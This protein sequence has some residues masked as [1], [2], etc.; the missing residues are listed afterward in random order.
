MI[1][2][3]FLAT[4]LYGSQHKQMEGSFPFQ[5][6]AEDGYFTTA[7]V[8]CYPENG[9]GLYDLAGNVWEIVQ[10]NY[11][12]GHTKQSKNNRSNP[13]R[14]TTTAHVI[15][16]GSYLCTPEFCMRYR[17]TARQPQDYTMG[18]SHIGFRTVLNIY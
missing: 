16:G 8:G 6:S 17:P 5:N 13:G 15:K 3:T 10:D 1:G 2:I 14:N 11:R 18:T 12:V 7:P 4:V 9:Y